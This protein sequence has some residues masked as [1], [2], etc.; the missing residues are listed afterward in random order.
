MLLRRE[1]IQQDQEAHVV[2]KKMKSILGIG[3]WETLQRPNS[4]IRTLVLLLQ[5]PLLSKTM[6]E[7]EEVKRRRISH[8]WIQVILW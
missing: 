7:V 4:L 8:P 2:R 6:E 1:K 3:E 5:L